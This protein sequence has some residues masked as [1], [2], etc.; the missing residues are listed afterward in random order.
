MSP[1]KH[2]TARKKKMQGLGASAF[3][4]DRAEVWGWIC[5]VTHSTN[6]ALSTLDFCF[7]GGYILAGEVD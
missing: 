4:K 6:R 1:S 2:S 7:H 3:K 5:S